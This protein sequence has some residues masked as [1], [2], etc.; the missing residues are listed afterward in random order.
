MDQ[1][2]PSINLLDVLRG[3]GRHKLLIFMLTTLGFAAGFG[4]VSTSTSLYTTE[5]QVLIENLASPFDRVQTPDLQP[6]QDVVDDRTIVSQISVMKSRDL[7]LRVA[8]ALNL[9]ERDEFDSLK[10]KGVG[11]LKEL[12]IRFGFSEDPRLMT[13]LERALKRY[14][15]QLNVYQVPMSNVVAVK[16][17][18][19]DPATAAEVANALVNIY[20]TST[21]EAKA[22]PTARARE[23]LGGQINELRQKLAKSEAEIE[24][25]R[26]EYGLL[27]GQ[28]STLGAQELSELN[29]QI[30]LAET[31]RTEAEERAREINEIL[32]TRGTVDA[33][34]DVLN[35]P[36]VQR[37]RDQQATASRK[38]AELSAIYLPNHPKMM[39]A[40]NDLTNI[41]RQ[42][43]S[44]ALKVVEG[45]DQQAKIAKA[46]QDSLRARLDRM[47]G[48]TSTANLDDVKLQAMI[49]D[50]TAD[51]AL[52]ESLLLRYADASARQNIATQPGF[53]RVIQAADTPTS[54]SYP[55]TGPMVL[56]L[57]MAG[58]ALSLGLSFLI[59]IMRSA[60][61]AN[62]PQLIAGQVY[63]EKPIVQVPEVQP[64]PAILP[65]AKPVSWP[66]LGVMPAGTTDLVNQELMRV[67]AQQDYFGLMST[68]SNAANWALELRTSSAMHHMAILSIGGGVS[69]SSMAA[70]VIARSFAAKKARVVVVDLAAS[71]SSIEMLFGLPVGPGFVDLLTGSADF[72]K[73]IVR[74][75]SSTAHLLRF[76]FERN[77]IS[78]ELLNQKTDAVLAALGN[79]YDVVIVHA[80][81]TS[82]QATALVAKCQAALLLAP[83]HRMAEASNAARGLSNNGRIKIQLVRLEPWQQ[84]APQYAATA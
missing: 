61:G 10:T 69:D 76:G 27:K 52:L 47:K 81:G 23:W 42:I 49:R 41:D 21:A 17:A 60:S 1:Q 68:A 7:A 67:S 28:T 43:R 45:L 82:S 11:P 6:Q 79:I 20:V 58:F 26:A 64:E 78:L 55:K 34:T 3:I 63:T 80:G 62:A 51:K 57:T 12:L 8:S 30:T 66:V 14:F 44:E 74:D 31:A 65:V 83:A 16:Y 15:S 46:R 5:A 19:N 37:L 50:S 39:A 53:A 56:L 48:D 75:P 54:P 72:T 25:F 59:E 77:K 9:Q 22:V 70:V 35:S 36:N 32:S 71:G 2:A 40:Q 33:S 4:L 13:P 24:T 29:T 38:V 73:V 84:N 18:S